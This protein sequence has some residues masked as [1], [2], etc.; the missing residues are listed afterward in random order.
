MGAQ[1]RSHER[2]HSAHS[3][4]RTTTDID[5][6]PPATVHCR[7]DTLAASSKNVAQ[8]SLAHTLMPPRAHPNAMPMVAVTGLPPQGCEGKALSGVAWVGAQNAS[9]PHLGQPVFTLHTSTAHAQQPTQQQMLQRTTFTAPDDT[10]EDAEKFLKQ[11]QEVFHLPISEAASKLGMGVTVLKKQCRKIGIP[12]W[13]YR[14]LASIEKLI[15]SVE[16]V[17][18]AFPI[19]V[20]AGSE[21]PSTLHSICVQEVS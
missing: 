15:Q 17:I 13:P 1:G 20:T 5:P 7:S 4:D 11:V 18:L 12:R 6:E 21:A 9:G 3:S 19:I 8:G 14:K 10:P 2:H 16:K